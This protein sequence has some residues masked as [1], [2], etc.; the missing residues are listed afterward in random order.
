M[1]RYEQEL[2]GA[3]LATE[4]EISLVTNAQKAALTTLRLH[5]LSSETFHPEY[6]CIDWLTSFKV[7]DPSYQDK[8]GI[9]QHVGRNYGINDATRYAVGDLMYHAGGIAYELLWHRKGYKD[10]SLGK[11]DFMQADAMMEARK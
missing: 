5:Y 2:L 3:L 10:V 7:S 8:G 11:I 9:M 4:T 1:S 6:S